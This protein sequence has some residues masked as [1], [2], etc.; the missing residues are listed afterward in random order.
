MYK[1]LELSQK[2]EWKIYIGQLPV[3]Q[4][5]VYYT[6]EYYEL[7]ENHGDGKAQ[8]FV[9]EKDGDVALYPFLINSINTLGYEL[10]K[11]YFDI[12]GAYGYNGVV[13][14]SY[15]PGFINDFYK[16]FHE[17]CLSNCIVAEFT[18]FNPILNN[19]VF[20][21]DY[22][23]IIVDRKTVG[24]K[25]LLYNNID[26]IVQNSYNKEARKNYRK[27]L[28]QGLNYTIASDNEYEL[29][30]KLYLQTMK[31]IGAE[32]YYYFSEKF[33]RDFYN[34]LGDNQELILAWSNNELVGGF[35]TLYSTN[36]AHNFLSA[37]SINQ[38]N[39]N[40]NEYMQHIAIERALN[41]D[42]KAIH[43]GGGNTNS[44]EDPLFRFKA[45]FS[46]QRLFFKIGKKIYNEKTYDLLVR[47]WQSKYP[48]SY[49]V[50]SFRLLG[51]REI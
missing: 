15:N 51:Y 13:S 22:I 44:I 3:D 46:K 16:A 20:S 50:N 32:S 10:D 36:Y 21:Q 35:A 49:K 34:L 43:F 4:Q 38:R 23:D 39:L 31:A 9:F 11:E 42:C 17:Y 30:Y 6:P 28:K 33:M 7:Y 45:K 41:R 26:E 29:F 40:I 27:A 5:D 48:E 24:I 14:S 1:V 8:C 2:N 19:S 25:L 12:Q 47:Q 37:G 18:R